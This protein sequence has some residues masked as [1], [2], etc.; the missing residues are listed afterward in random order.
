MVENKK[1][2]W[3]A[4]AG[5]G[6]IAAAALIIYSL[7]GESGEGEE[8]I[9]TEALKAAGIDEVKR[10]GDMIDS[11]YFL[12]LLQFIGE[13]TRDS[14][15]SKR[16]EITAARRK[17][18]EAKDWDAYREE[19]Q[20]AATM[21]DETAQRILMETIGQLDISEQE[22][23]MTHRMLASNEQT[24]QFVMAAQQGKLKEPA[25]PGLQK[26]PT[27]TKN[28]MMDALKHHMEATMVQMME[29]QKKQMNPQGDQMSMM[30]DMMVE[31]AKLADDMFLSHKVENDEFED[32]LMHYMSH[33]PQ[34]QQSMRQYMMK[35]QM[36]QGG[37]GGGMP[38]MGQ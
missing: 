18:Y 8:A 31:Q 9:D 25:A 26:K 28:K 16:D 22:F 10:E 19:V 27:L 14:T 12:K 29:M 36:M 7:G 3:M 38:G 2:L 5:V 4:L 33:D 35:M 24:A 34:V 15:K 6:A 30:V 21:E 11:K 32:N 13:K 37:M 20:K 17:H 23:S 1:T